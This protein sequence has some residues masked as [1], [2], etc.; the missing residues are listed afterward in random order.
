M[1]FIAFITSLL[2]FLLEKKKT[3]DEAFMFEFYE[4]SVLKKHHYL[5]CRKLL[6]VKLKMY[7]KRI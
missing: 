4:V 7:E 6:G 1:D 5:Y 2:I 3:H